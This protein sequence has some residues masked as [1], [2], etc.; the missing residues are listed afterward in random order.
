MN[1]WLVWVPFHFLPENDANGSH[2]DEFYNRIVCRPN[3]DIAKAMVCSCIRKKH[4][5]FA[6]HQ[7]GITAHVFLD[8][9]AHQGFAGI[10]HPINLASDI[11]LEDPR[12]DPQWSGVRETVRPFLCNILDCAFPMGH[13]TVLHYPDHPFRKW[14]YVNGQGQTVSRDNPRDFLEA[15]EELYKVIKPISAGILS[16]RSTPSNRTTRP[17]W[18][19]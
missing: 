10:R 1:G 9:W 5:P 15:I 7:L 6:L 17:L 14:S 13:G 11:H 2:K 12:H 4:R 19:R 3:S 8:T 18:R 16:P